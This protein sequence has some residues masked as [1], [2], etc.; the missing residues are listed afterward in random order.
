MFSVTGTKKPP[1]LC[2]D[3]KAYRRLSG[4][5]DFLQPGECLIGNDDSDCGALNGQVLYAPPYYECK[6]LQQLYMTDIEGIC[7]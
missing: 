7:Y 4:V 2:V 6:L 3:G 1:V 5:Q